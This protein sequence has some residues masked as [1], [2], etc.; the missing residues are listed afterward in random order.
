MIYGKA[1]KKPVKIDWF[2]WDYKNNN[3]LGLLEDWMGKNDFEKFTK[4]LPGGR[5][6]QV[7]T[8]EGHS[9]KIPNGYIIIRGIEGE[10]YPCDPE[11]FKKTYNKL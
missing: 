3:S 6:L 11:I 7:L 8:L 9:Y 1:T 2:E 4:Y 10:Y 5:D